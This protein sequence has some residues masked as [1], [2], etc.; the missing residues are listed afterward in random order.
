MR[1][2]TKYRFF[3]LCVFCFYTSIG[4]AQNQKV[5]N[6]EVFYFPFE[7]DTRIRVTSESI[8]TMNGTKYFFLEEINQLSKLISK[9]QSSKKNR[10]IDV[11][12]LCVVS[13][14]DGTTDLIAFDKWK[15]IK[16]NGVLMKKNRRLFNLIYDS[17]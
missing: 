7:I 5:L 9:L 16:Y 10:E 14:K 6:V 11:R 12:L 2:F 4:M 3:M 13:Y 8:R 15:R 17:R 1:I